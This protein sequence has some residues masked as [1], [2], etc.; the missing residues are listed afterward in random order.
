MT[1][2]CD[3]ARL[4][5]LA[6]ALGRDGMDEL[7][8]LFLRESRL[9]VQRLRQAAGSPTIIRAEAH[10]LHGAGAA[11]GATGLAALAEQLATAARAGDT[12]CVLVLTNGVGTEL[13]RVAA[14]LEHWTL[15][16]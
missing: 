9:R 13:D 3:E 10:Q 4:T 8:K 12:D 16:E 1:A 6:S 11:L 5:E 7:T 15:P 14:F 2:A